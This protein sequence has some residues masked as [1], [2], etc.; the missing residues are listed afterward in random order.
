MSTNIETTTSTNNAKISTTAGK[1]LGWI[2]LCLGVLGFF[3]LRIW[4]GIPALILGVIG[5]FSDQKKLNIFTVVVGAVAIIL[6]IVL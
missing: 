1:W 2:G 6:G 4:F 5:L 3:W